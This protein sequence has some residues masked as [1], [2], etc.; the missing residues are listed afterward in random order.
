MLRILLTVIVLTYSVSANAASGTPV[1]RYF[2]EVAH[3]TPTQSRQL[4]ALALYNSRQRVG[5]YW[6]AWPWTVYPSNHHGKAVRLRNQLELIRYLHAAPETPFGLYAL[7]RDDFVKHG[8]DRSDLLLLTQPQTQLNVVAKHFDGANNQWLL[9]IAEQ[10]NIAKPKPKRNRQLQ[11]RLPVS[12]NL[13]D[14]ITLNAKRYGVPKALIKAVIRAESAFNP[15]AVSSAGARGLMQV[16]PGTAREMGVNPDRLF[17]PAVAID[18]GTRYLAQQLKTF[19]SIKLA[20]AAYNAGPGAVRK[21]GNQ[22]PPY[23]ETQTYVRRVTR[24]HR[25]YLRQEKA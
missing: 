16:M 5:S 7:T 13:D 6:I 11:K 1:P 2:N 10:F 17:E 23:R 12:R 15:K 4:F 9:A 14:L 22:V 25:H 21:Y 24:F 18:A 8:Y 3:L 19:R 20:A